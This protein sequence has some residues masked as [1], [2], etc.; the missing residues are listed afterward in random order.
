MAENCNLADKPP[1]HE[2]PVNL[3]Q[4]EPLVFSNYARSGTLRTIDISNGTTKPFV[5]S[6]LSFEAREDGIPPWFGFTQQRLTP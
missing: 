5:M 4:A 6:I 2:N 3:S 1:I